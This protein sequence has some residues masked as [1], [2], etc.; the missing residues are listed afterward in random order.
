MNNCD[1][2]S[3]FFPATNITVE[4][5]AYLTADSGGYAPG[6]GEG[7]GIGHATG[8]SGG[9]HGGTGGQG[10]SATYTGQ[11]YDSVHTPRFFGSGGGTDRTVTTGYGG[12]AIYIEATNYIEVDGTIRANGQT[13][14]ETG[15]G[16]GAGGSVYLS[17]KDF[18]GMSSYHMSL[19]MRK[20]SSG[21][22]T[23]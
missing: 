6:S 17:A 9:S 3:I 12:G 18:L 20:L 7:A 15:V 14:S 22:A 16:G 21:V 8:S 19:V 23:S 5:A 13:A 2:S 10:S 1:N 4:S 11:A